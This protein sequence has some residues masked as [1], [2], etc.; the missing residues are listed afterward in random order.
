MGIKRSIPEA[1]GQYDLSD[2]VCFLDVRG[3]LC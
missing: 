2:L 1:I 3:V